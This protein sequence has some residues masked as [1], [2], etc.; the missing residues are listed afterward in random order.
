MFN[1]S[2]KEEFLLSKGEE[3]LSFAFSYKAGMYFLRLFIEER[4]SILFGIL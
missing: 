3:A 1:L 2:F 4:G